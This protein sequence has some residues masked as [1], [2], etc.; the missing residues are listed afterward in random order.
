MPYEHDYL[1]SL[2]LKYKQG[3]LQA[4]EDL[5]QQG[6]KLVRGIVSRLAGYAEDKE[7][8]FQVGCIGLLKAIDRYTLAGG[9]GF[10]TLAFIYVTNEIRMYRRE[11]NCI[12]ISR[13]IKQQGAEMERVRGILRSRMKR[14]PTL[15]EL[16]GEMGSRESDLVMVQEACSLPLSLEERPQESVCPLEQA[17]E[18]FALREMLSKLP[19][20]EKR[21][22]VLR[23]YRG[24]NQVQTA[25][26]MGVSQTQVSRLEGRAIELLRNWMSDRA[27]ICC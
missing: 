9:A 5:L 18:S 17:V 1:T 16:A 6:M 10:P 15:K 27:N 23:Y 19:E 11:N 13:A 21:V 2:L 24:M 22:I 26:I 3:D 20:Q 25:E 7:D 14:E 4:F 12:K 8:L